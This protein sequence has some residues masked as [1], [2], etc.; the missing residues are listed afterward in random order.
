MNIRRFEVPGLAQYSYMISSS[1]EAV[2]IDAIRDFDRYTDYAAE[3]GLKI[4][5][6]TE[7]HIHADF[8][9]GS[10]GL[11]EATGAEL[12]L[13]GYDEGELYQYAMPHRRLRNGDAIEL[14]GLRLEAL[15][16]P[17]HTPE[18]LSFVLFDLERSATKPTAI[19]T[20]DFLFVGSLG[21][22][23]LLGE[24]AKL[25]LAHELYRSF[26]ARIAELPDSVAVYPGHGAGSLCGAGMS[27]G[28]DS[29]LGHERATQ[30]L[31]GLSEREFVE[32]ILATAPPMPAYYP[33]MK[34]LNAAGAPSGVTLP[35][36]RGIGAAELKDLLAGGDVTVLDLRGPEA[37]GKAHIAGAIN[38]GAGQNLSLWAGW[39]LDAER[40]VVLVNKSGDDEESRRALV[41]VGLDRITGFLAGGMPVWIEAGFD[42][43]VMPQLSVQ[44]VASRGNDLLVLDVRHDGE[45]AAGHIAGAEHIMLG[46]LPRRVESLRKDRPIVTVC[47]SGYRASVAA[48]LL[49]AHGVQDVSIMAGGMDAWTQHGLHTA[50]QA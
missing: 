47:G 44:Q 43:N 9:S 39:L 14:G 46:D 27:E 21:R 18:H 8:A 48:S 42:F 34:R 5:H 16:T 40:P 32:E 30:R 3:H 12:A 38:I 41:R 45:W 49:E 2:V 24:E 26:H 11:A 23:D 19:F 29:T 22:P 35:G 7:T 36:A 20:G 13:S 28:A 33:R 4:R 50:A 25:G 1:G 6:I 17:G 37:F 10:V 31:F 15:H